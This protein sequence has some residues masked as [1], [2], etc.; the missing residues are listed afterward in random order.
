MF[1]FDFVSENWSHEIFTEFCEKII[2]D[3]DK[4]KLGLAL[5]KDF[6]NLKKEYGSDMSGIF[7]NYLDIGETYKSLFMDGKSSLDHIVWELLGKKLSKFE[8][9]SCWSSRPLRKSQMHYAAM[10]A[11]VLNRLYK[12]F[13]DMENG[14][15]DEIMFTDNFGF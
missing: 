3:N 14:V 13:V 7:R 1:L 10:D 4:L 6:E 9:C 15:Y 8:Q 11:F 5:K 12:R 2:A